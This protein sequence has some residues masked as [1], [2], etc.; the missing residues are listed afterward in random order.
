MFTFLTL[1]LGNSIVHHPDL[2][3]GQ[4]NCS[5]FWTTL[6]LTFLTLVLDSPN[7]HLPDLGS[8]QS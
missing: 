5:G 6:S 1:G 4:T 2:G 7:V 3:S 8:G